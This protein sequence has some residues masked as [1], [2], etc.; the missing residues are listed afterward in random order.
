MN[1]VLLESINNREFA[2]KE[3][4]KITG[5]NYKDDINLNIEI[6]KNCIL[7]LVLFTKEKNKNINLKLV[8]NDNSNLLIVIACP[9]A[10]LAEQWAKDISTYMS[11]MYQIIGKNQSIF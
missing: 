1:S 4:I 8:L 5:I 11:E 10:H 6:K 3:D 9:Y 2:V 7:E